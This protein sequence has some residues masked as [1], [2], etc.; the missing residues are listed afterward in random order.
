[1]PDPMP[2]TLEDLNKRIL[3]LEELLKK[4]VSPDRVADLEKRLEALKAAREE[5]KEEVKEKTSTPEPEKKK[6]SGLGWM[7]GGG[8]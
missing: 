4:A 7:F 1:M 3:A 5:V 2:P 6:A 8:D